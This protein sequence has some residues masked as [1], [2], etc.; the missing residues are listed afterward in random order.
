MREL[1]KCSFEWENKIPKEWMEVRLKDVLSKQS[2]QISDD[3]QIVICSNQGKVTYRGEKNPGL[4]SMT[5]N[6]YQGV[7]PGDLLIHGMDT[8]HGAIAISGIRGKCTGVVHVCESRQS[9]RFIAYYLQSLAF[10]NVYKALSNGVRQNTSD[11]RSW[12]KA[13]SIP[14]VLPLL[15][16]QCRIADYL[17]SKCMEIDKAIKAAEASIEEYSFY[18][19]SVIFQAVTKGLNPDVPMKDSGIEWIGAIPNSWNAVPQKR[20][21]RKIK[22]ICEKWSGEDVLSLTVDG[23]IVRDLVN[24]KGKMPTTFDG[25]QFVSNG[26]L[27]LCLFDIDVTPRCVGIIRNNG[28]TSPAYSQFELIDGDSVEFY[29]WYLRAMDDQ[30]LYLHLTSTLRSSFTADCFGKIIACRPPL[31]EQIEISN[32]LENKCSEIDRAIFAKREIINELNEYKKS[33]IWETVTGKREV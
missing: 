7:N 3:D 28:V 22:T 25:Y 29:Y 21:M 13:G 27:L 10:R 16:E 26:N 17:D 1:K 15:S 2:R 32:Y 4:V 24:P 18:K 19:K 12:Q 14:I 23:V 8:W 5:E 30:K 6:G 11:F 9:K 20:L 31:H 33:L